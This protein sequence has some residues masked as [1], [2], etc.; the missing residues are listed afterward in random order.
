ML[1]LNSVVANCNNKIWCLAKESLYLE[2]LIDSEQFLHLKVSTDEGQKLFCMFVYA[3]CDKVARREIWGSIRQILEENE[4]WMIGG[5]FNTVLSLNERMSGRYPRHH[6]I[7]DFNEAIFDSGLIDVDF[8]GA[9]FTWTNNRLWQRL[10]RALF[11]S[12]WIDSFSDTKVHHL[13][14]YNL[15]I[16]HY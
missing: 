16:V 14:H 7:E 2:V 6:F 11:L 10:D 1:G 8:E 13:Q 4:A 3:K 15:I 5:D 9:P 12:E